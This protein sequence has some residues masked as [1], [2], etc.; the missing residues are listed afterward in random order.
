MQQLRIGNVTV[1]SIIERD[2]P[3]RM[4]ADLFPFPQSAYFIGNINLK[5]ISIEAIHTS[6]PT[7][8]AVRWTALSATVMSCKRR[9]RASGSGA[10]DFISTTTI[11]LFSLN[12]SE[13]ELRELGFRNTR[14][15]G[16][17][18][19]MVQIDGVYPSPTALCGS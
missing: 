12:K 19:T 16:S 10:V 4:P 7:T 11:L 14:R 13:K 1:D 6:C 15:S 9:S 8:P 18:V 17:R 5:I 3:W 2:G